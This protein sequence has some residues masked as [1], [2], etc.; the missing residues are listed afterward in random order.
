[1]CPT[2]EIIS[3]FT[4]RRSTLPPLPSPSPSKHTEQI[5]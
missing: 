3:L 5:S 4:D 2:A 1:M